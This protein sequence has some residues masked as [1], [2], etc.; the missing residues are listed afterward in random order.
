MIPSK[1]I[2]AI[3]GL[4][5]LGV[6]MFT[7]HNDAAL[8]PQTLKVIVNGN[9]YGSSTV[10]GYRDSKPLVLTCAHVVAEEGPIIVDG[11]PAH[12]L[13]VDPTVDLAVLML[14]EHRVY[15]VATI[16]AQSPSPGDEELVVG[17]PL[18]R[19]ESITHGYFGS[20]QDNV[21]T[22]GSAA[23]YPGNSGGGAYTWHLFGGWQLAGVADAVAIGQS[24][25]GRYI[26]PNV[27]FTVSLDVVRKFLKRLDT[28]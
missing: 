16:A 5:L 22:Q 20:P 6:A 3:T 10:I 2:T 25:F 26:A 28:A 1:V 8:L 13:L 23:V 27:S 18:A 7:S 24:E 11:H 17:Y 15:P 12:V 21:T 19:L 4:V 14:D 9:V